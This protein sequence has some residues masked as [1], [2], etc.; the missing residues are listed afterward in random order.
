MF[1]GL[2]ASPNHH[3]G[4]EPAHPV[5]RNPRAGRFDLRIR[6]RHRELGSLR[7]WRTVRRHNAVTVPPAA[8]P[9]GLHE[10]L[11]EPAPHD[12]HLRI[13]VMLQGVQRE[14]QPD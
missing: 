12:R 14:R 2:R 3:P 7:R 5:K 4:K 9:Y 13:R 6:D 10:T 11:E 1:L 8:M